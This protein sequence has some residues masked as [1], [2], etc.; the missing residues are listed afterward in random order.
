MTAQ[1]VQNRPA[2]ARPVASAGEAEALIGHYSEVMETLLD[3]I[4]QETELVRAGH[5][6]EA[7]TLERHKSELAGLYLVDTARLEA[8]KPYLAQAMPQMLRT[9]RG[10]HETFRSLLQINLTVLATAHAVSEGIIRSVSEEINRNA[11]PQIYGASG[12]STAPNPR[13]AQP[14]TVCRSL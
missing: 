11:A 4:E 10:R 14:L 13:N 7:A 9:L 6:R 12:R 2:P 1:P 8:S 3:L 5:L